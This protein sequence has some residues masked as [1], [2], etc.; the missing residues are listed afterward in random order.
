MYK[1]SQ[2]YIQTF[3]GATNIMYMK[4]VETKETY[5]AAAGA[6]AGALALAV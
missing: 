4:E 6:A 3:T 2:G 1:H 5:A